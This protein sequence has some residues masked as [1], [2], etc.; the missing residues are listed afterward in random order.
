MM[1]F[2]RNIIRIAEISTK[3]TESKCPLSAWEAEE[4][5][6]AF[7]A[8]AASTKNIKAGDAICIYPFNLY[9][10]DEYIEINLPVAIPTGMSSEELEKLKMNPEF[11]EKTDYDFIVLN[12]EEGVQRATSSRRRDVPSHI[13]FHHWEDNIITYVVRR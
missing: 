10:Q 5:K 3:S 4:L 13:T 11:I 6:N 8:V 7:E 2:I 12:K 1:N 9:T